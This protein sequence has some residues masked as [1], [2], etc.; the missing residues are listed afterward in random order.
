MNCLRLPLFVRAQARRAPMSS[1]VFVAAVVLGIHAR[2]LLRIFSFEG[3][4]EPKVL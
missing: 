4:G 1:W 3:S 2:S